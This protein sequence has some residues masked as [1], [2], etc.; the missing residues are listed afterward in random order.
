MLYISASG[1]I[2]KQT[3]NKHE[4]CVLLVYYTAC[5]GNHA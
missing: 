5:S 1:S 4:T 3:I 2:I